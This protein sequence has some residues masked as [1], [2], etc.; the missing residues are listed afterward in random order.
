VGGTTTGGAGTGSGFL[1]FGGRGYEFPD[2]N[3]ER[4]C[5][6]SSELKYGGPGIDTPVPRIHGRRFGQAAAGG[7]T[8]GGAGMGSGFLETHA[9]SI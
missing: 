1:E 9:L 3:C 8:A 4:T 5:L 2:A 6:E 7:T